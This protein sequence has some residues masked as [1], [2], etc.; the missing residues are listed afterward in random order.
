MSSPFYVLPV[1]TVS[2]QRCP[3]NQNIV[4]LFVIDALNLVEEHTIV[5]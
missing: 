2:T 3:A 5:E 1:E 4:P